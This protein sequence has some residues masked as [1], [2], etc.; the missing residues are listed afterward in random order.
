[1]LSAWTWPMR[2]APMIPMLRRR[3]VSSGMT[4]FKLSLGTSWTD[5]RAVRGTDGKAARIERRPLVWP[6]NS[7]LEPGGGD[8]GRKDECRG[9]HGEGVVR[10]NWIG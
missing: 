2:P 9:N 5:M 10:R 8:G 6:V 3:S 7:R 1:M 4:A